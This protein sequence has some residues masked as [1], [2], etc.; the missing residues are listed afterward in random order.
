MQAAR[1]VAQSLTPAGSWTDV[2][3]TTPGTEGRSWWH[4]GT[5]LQRTIVLAMASR[6]SPAEFAAPARRALCFW[7]RGDFSNS[8]WWWQWI[9]TPRA[10]AKALLLLPANAS[11]A[12]LPLALPILNRSNLGPRICGQRNG[13]PPPEKNGLVLSIFL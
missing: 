1:E 2:N 9:G 5:H 3:Y 10:V 13:F 8:N 7:L 12:L 4:A 6:D 11:A